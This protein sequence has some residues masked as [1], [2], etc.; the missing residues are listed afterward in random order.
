V[1]ACMCVYIYI[2]IYISCGYQH[3]PCL[4]KLMPITSSISGGGATKAQG[5][6]LA[7]D[8]C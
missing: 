1:Y 3:K 8:A 7:V 2:Y 5:E 6:L 4:Y